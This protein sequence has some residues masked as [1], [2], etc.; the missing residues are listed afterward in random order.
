[1]FFV[2]IIYCLVF[3]TITPLAPEEPHKAEDD[4]LL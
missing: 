3:I 2:F 1:M 4:A